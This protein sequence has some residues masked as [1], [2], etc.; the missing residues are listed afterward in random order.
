MKPQTQAA[1]LRESLAEL[2]RAIGHLVYSA[3][4]CADLSPHQTAPTEEAL[5]RIEAFTSRFARVVDLM[6]K[7]V[8][9][10]SVALLG[11][12]P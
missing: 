12:L 3:N 11:S 1:Y 10:Y 7:R 2:D 4:A 5:A 9:N 6:S 8:R